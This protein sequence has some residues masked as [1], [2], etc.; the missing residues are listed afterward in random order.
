MLRKIKKFWAILKYFFTDEENLFLYLLEIKAFECLEDC[1]KL[2][3]SSTEELEDLIFHIRSY[4]EVPNVIAEI[5]YPEFKD[6][7]IKDIVKKYKDKKADL[8]EINR[9]G[10]FLIEVEEQRAVERD[11]MFDLAKSLTFGFKL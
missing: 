11:F 3:I 1:Y 2:D 9:Y 10:D 6:M 8:E 7:T 4:R 5:K